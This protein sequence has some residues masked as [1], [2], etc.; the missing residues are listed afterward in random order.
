MVFAIKFLNDKSLT[1]RISQKL[2]IRV[3]VL[4]YT[5]FCVLVIAFIVDYLIFLNHELPVFF[6]HVTV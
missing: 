5:A 1:E 6:V 3:T 2:L 4:Q